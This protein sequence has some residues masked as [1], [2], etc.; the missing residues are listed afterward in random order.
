VRTPAGGIEAVGKLTLRGVSK[1]LRLPLTL[2]PT[3][4]GLELSGQ[5]AI[6][7]LDYGVGQGE[8]QST[9]SVGDE[10]KIR[11]KVALVRVK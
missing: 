2:K 9:E 8:W 4:T 5:T 10:V 3:A 7:R 11:Y 1:D 6:K